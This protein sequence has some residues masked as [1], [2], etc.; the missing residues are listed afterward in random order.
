MNSLEI[1]NLASIAFS[2][3]EMFRLTGKLPLHNSDFNTF[4]SFIQNFLFLLIS[5]TLIG[6]D[7]SPI[8]VMSLLITFYGRVM[9]DYNHI[10]SHTS[11]KSKSLNKETLVKLMTR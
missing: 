4:L 7:I 11:I 5:F 6:K 3:A 2:Y 8:L 1:V 9:D 10:Y